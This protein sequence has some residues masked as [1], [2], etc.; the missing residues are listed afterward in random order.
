MTMKEVRNFLH[1]RICLPKVQLLNTFLPEK[2]ALYTYIYLNIYYIS[3]MIIE[4]IYIFI[5]YD[6]IYIFYTYNFYF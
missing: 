2:N 1:W 5:N 6:Y 4:Y 3:F